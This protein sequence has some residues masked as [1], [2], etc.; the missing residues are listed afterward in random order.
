MG[1]R[2]HRDDPKTY[3]EVIFDID[4]EKW[5]DAMKSEIDSMH[6]NQVWVLVDP[7]EGIV[8]IGCKWIYKRK[9]G[10]DGKVETY[11]ARLVSK[12]YSQRKGIDYQGTFSPVAMLKSIRTL[13]ALA[14]YYDDEI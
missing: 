14:A 8:P 2:E 3:N 4:S 12:G 7:P 5:L 13:L 10:S 11:K 9:I 6:S 1:D